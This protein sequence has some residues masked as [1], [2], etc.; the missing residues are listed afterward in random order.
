MRVTDNLQPLAIAWFVLGAIRLMTGLMAALALHTFAHSGFLFNDL[1]AF[2]P[3]WLGSLASMIAVSSSVW[4]LASLFVGWSLQERKPW[5]RGVA[6]FMAI[7]ALFKF[8]VGT[9][10]GIYTLWVMVPAA[11]ATEWRTIEQ[12]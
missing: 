5:A 4:G 7:L 2:P 8:P 9:A 3:A 6:I 10:V 1:P 12:A 11:S